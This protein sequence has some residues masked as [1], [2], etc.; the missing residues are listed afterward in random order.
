M[1]TVD[2]QIE[3]LDLQIQTLDLQIETVYLQIADLDRSTARPHWRRRRAGGR[4]APLARRSAAVRPPLAGARAPPA[5][6]EP[7]LDVD[8]SAPSS[9]RGWPAS[10]GASS[11]GPAPRPARARRR[12]AS[13]DRQPD[14]VH[15]SLV[16]PNRETDACHR[17]TDPGDRQLVGGD[18]QQVGGD[19]Q[20]D[21][22]D[23]S[24]AAAEAPA[25]RAHRQPSV[26][27]SK[28]A[29]PSAKPAGLRPRPAG[30]RPLVVERRA[31][32]PEIVF[33]TDGRCRHLAAG[34]RQAAHSRAMPA[35]TGR[36]PASKLSLPH[37]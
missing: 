24:P 25:A 37:S 9:R 14:P 19:L 13:A 1:E 11:T 21:R 31:P 20:A 17:S 34:R 16:A 8:N 27:E 26:L 28:P 18:L 7:R 2:L 29:S 32:P 35:G 10:P 36:H 15:R 6:V 3:T 5:R 30:P 33:H 23:R 12:A 4:L 22:G